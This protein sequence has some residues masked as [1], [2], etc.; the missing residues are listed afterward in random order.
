[1]AHEAQTREWRRQNLPIHGLALGP[2]LQKKQNGDE[3]AGFP[4]H[5]Q[6]S[7]LT[8]LQPNRVSIQQ[9]KEN[10][11]C[12]EGLKTHRK[13]SRQPRGACVEGCEVCEEIRHCKLCE[14]C[15]KTS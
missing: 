11:S 13:H 6:C 9:N 4:L 3:A 12:T 1:M 2:H 7:L 5:L 14:S 10:F 15:I 8:R